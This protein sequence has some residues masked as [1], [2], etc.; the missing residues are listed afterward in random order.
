MIDESKF[1]LLLFEFVDECKIIKTLFLLKT[2][3]FFLIG[4]VCIVEFRDKEQ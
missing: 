1:W 2:N 3:V 4:L